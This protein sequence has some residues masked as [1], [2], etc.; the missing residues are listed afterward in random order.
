MEAVK[1]LDPLTGNVLMNPTRLGVETLRREFP[2]AAL[3]NVNVD[4]DQV[5]ACALRWDER[6]NSYAERC[7][8]ALKF[9]LLACLIEYHLHRGHV[10]VY[11]KNGRSR[12]PSALMG[13]F[14]IFRGFS[15]EH[16]VL[17][18]FQEAYAKMRPAT[19]AVSTDFPNYNKY[20]ESLKMIE[21]FFQY[22]TSGYLQYGTSGYLF[23]GDNAAFFGKLPP[24]PPR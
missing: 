3:I 9:L 12:S 11:C 18:W 1:L 22:G 10:I 17:P 14:V 2:D 13:F 20:C 4:D 24:A 19:A 21:S 8:V 7:K 16:N 6:P 15:L 5:G 23:P